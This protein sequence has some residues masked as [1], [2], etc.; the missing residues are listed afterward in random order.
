MSR[1]TLPL[2]FTGS[3]G[4]KLAARLDSPL[5][6]PRAYALFAHC[7]TCS[8][9]IF[10]ASRISAELAAQGIAVLRFDFTGLGRSEG[11]FANTNFSSNVQDLVRAA[12][13]LRDNFEAP[14]ILV[15][16]SLGGAAVLVAAGEI[17]EARAVATIGAPADAE[18]VIHNF[19]AQIGEIE[20]KGVAQV[21]LAGRRFSIRKEFL[22][23][24]KDQS[25]LERV[26]A[27]R[28]AL[29]LFHAPRDEIVGIENASAI[30]KAAK[31]PKS[32]ISLDDADHLLS[33]RADAAYVAQVLAAWASRYL[34]PRQEESRLPYPGPEGQVSVAETGK[35][36]F[37][38]EI[39]ARSHR[40]FADEPEGV[41]GLDSGPT[42]YDLL[43][44]ALGACTTMTLR[45]YAERKK[46]PLERVGVHVRHDKVHADDCR[47]CEGREGRVDRFER[48]IVLQGAL[49]S[50]AREKLL[51][52]ADKCPVHRTLE[53]SS[54][55]VTRI[56]GEPKS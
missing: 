3:S 50:Q 37:Q 45:M 16:H 18:H 51:E 6:T 43:A 26:A 53:Q 15:G 4:E 32:F 39:V 9:D 14:Q 11:E 10:A 25:V 38:A 20:E 23:D 42:P 55:I 12:D 48:E 41:G 5:R 34:E 30:F 56:A 21:S 29:L 17:G 22:D 2:T 8:K 27:L 1:T 31:H 7:F 44:A 33:R 52:I 19:S 36:R 54:V 49:D 46:L 47:E 28:K 35:G 13:F 24:L 40:F